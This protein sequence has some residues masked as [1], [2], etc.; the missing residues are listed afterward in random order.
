M[1]G[2]GEAQGYLFGRPMPEAQLVDL[3]KEWPALAA[4]A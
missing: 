2:C 3:L 1:S 4:S